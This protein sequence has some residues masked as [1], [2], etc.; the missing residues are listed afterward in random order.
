MT[1]KSAKQPLVTVPTV[2]VP[3]GDGTWTLRAGKP[4]V[5]SDVV[6]TRKAARILG[7]SMRRVQSLCEEGLIE[8]ER[9]GGPRG[10][11][12]LNLESVL[13]RKARTE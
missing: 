8:H 7:L 3:A 11:Y 9:P 6:G 12:R 2:V 5:E 10:N 13:A 4:I 1:P